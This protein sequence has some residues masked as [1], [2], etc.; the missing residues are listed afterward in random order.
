MRIIGMLWQNNID[1][2]GQEWVNNWLKPTRIQV[3]YLK[4]NRFTSYANYKHIMIFIV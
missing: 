2:I 4:L 3:F 1:D